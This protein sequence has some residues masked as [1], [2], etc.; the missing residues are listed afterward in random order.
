MDLLGNGSSYKGV[1]SGG[2]HSHVVGGISVISHT[3]SSG[4]SQVSKIPDN[5]RQTH[6][7]SLNSRSF[8]AE[9]APG[10]IERKVIWNSR[11]LPEISNV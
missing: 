9:A 6:H 10:S 4:S 5:L 2:Q 3:S 8:L 1:G 7:L 11:D